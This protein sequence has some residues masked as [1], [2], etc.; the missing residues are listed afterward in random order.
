MQDNEPDG[1]QPQ[2]RSS[3][4]EGPAR[5]G[6]FPGPAARR[7]HHGAAAPAPRPGPVPAWG[8]PPA[9]V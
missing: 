7:L 6:P 9:P 8:L 2:V 4:P 5:R 1:P 3:R